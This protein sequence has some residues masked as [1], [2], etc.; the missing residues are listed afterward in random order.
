MAIAPD[1][2]IHRE[3]VAA[4]RSLLSREPSASIS[5]I[6]R[7]AGVSR[8]TIYRHF[9]SRDALLT[10]I[11]MEAPV[12][13]R[14]RILEAGAELL[15]RGGLHTF[16]MDELADAAGVSRATVYRLFPT[17]AALFGEIV[18][19][20]SPFEQA[21]AV[22]REH[23][24]R[25]PEVVVP[26]IAR[27]VVRVAAPRIGVIRGLLAE[28]SMLEP[29]AIAGVRPFMSE[30]ISVLGGYF[31][32]QMAAGRVRRMHPVLAVQAVLGPVFVH[33]LTR[34]IAE[35]L[36]AFEL[37]LDEAAD[38]LTASILEGLAA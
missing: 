5:R 25:P 34:P 22:V 1:P 38:E 33:L 6:A 30:A 9:G 37:P 19:A 29:D 27:T 8:A 4:A 14:Q 24:D 13:A 7:E 15:G 28:A 11:E 18:R 20:Y 10:A 3:V 17:K 36:V 31:A 12:P 21:V 26:M 23:G 2:T 32:R 16:T 35:L